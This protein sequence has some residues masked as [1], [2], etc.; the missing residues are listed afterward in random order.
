M[1]KFLKIRVNTMN[2]RIGRG[3]ISIIILLPTSFFLNGNLVHG[4]NNIQIDNFGN[5]DQF[6]PSSSPLKPL[7]ANT[8]PTA[9]SQLK[10]LTPQPIQQRSLKSNFLDPTAFISV[11]DTALTSD[12]SSGN[13]E[14]HLP[15]MGI[16]TYNFTIDWGDG[17]SSQITDWEQ[18]NTTHTYNAEGNYTL[19]ITGTIIGWAFN[20]GGDKLKILE[21]IQWGNLQLGNLGGYFYGSANLV[22]NATDIPNLNGITNF[23]NAFTGCFSLGNTG[24][25]DS[26]DVSQI[27]DMGS[28]FQ[29]A[30]TF[31]QS[32]SSWNVSKVTDMSWMFGGLYYF[33]YTIHPIFDKPLNH[34]D[35]SH[36]TDMSGMFYSSTFN[37]SLDQ[38]DVSHVRYMS[39]MFES[40][41]FNL[42][43]DQ[44]DVTSVYDMS[45]MFYYSSFN[46]PINQWDVS[47][48]RYMSRMFAN[49]PFNQTLNNWDVSQVTDMSLMFFSATSFNQALNQWDVS[50]VTTMELMLNDTSFST[51]NYNALLIAWAKLSL[52]Q[53]V[54]FDVG[55]TQ[56]S[57][58]AVAAHNSIIDNFSWFIHDGGMVSEVLPNSST[59]NTTN[60]K[61]GLGLMWV[62]ITLI[63]TVIIEVRVREENKYD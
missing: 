15:L 22:I 8:V 49:S 23:H 9:Q 52:Q 14:I 2:L 16:G 11:W 36:V 10:A 5:P 12:D 46:Q 50:Q 27:T 25:F 51:L 42:P 31:N 32:L 29:G 63:L 62:E 56:Y 20:N 48:V 33:G 59:R 18:T 4:Q 58:S 37:Q 39:R 17:N 53:S 19:Q 34:W 47:H 55:A 30:R 26:W 6:N 60:S 1:L 38:W 13:M 54:I 57:Q 61:T 43:L 44:W 24:N 41:S 7:N 35:V 40:S 28:M 21:I 45:R 3:L